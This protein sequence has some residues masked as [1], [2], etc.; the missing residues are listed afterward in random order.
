M[1]SRSLGISHTC[2]HERYKEYDPDEISEIQDEEKLLILESDQL[3][4]E[5]L[6]KYKELS[7]GFPDFLA[8][9]W[10]THMNEILSSRETLSAEEI[11]QILETGVIFL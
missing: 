8:R 2:H 3:F 6:S 11:S 4:E 7:L 9:F 10:W 5:F 1:T